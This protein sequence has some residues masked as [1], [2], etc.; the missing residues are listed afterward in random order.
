[1]AFIDINKLKNSAGK[2]IKEAADWT[3]QAV[4]D[5]SEWTQQAAKDATVWTAQAAQDASDWTRQASKTVGDSATDFATGIIVKLLKGLDLDGFMKN[6]EDYHA[7]TGKDVQATV[8]FINK[9]I[10]LRDGK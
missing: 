7:Q 4:K 3:Q 6:I 8:T 5:A 9:L 1:M 2:A 10:D